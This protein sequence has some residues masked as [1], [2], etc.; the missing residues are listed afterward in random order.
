MAKTTG[1]PP[2]N[3]PPSS[4]PIPLKTPLWNTSRLICEAIA[5]RTLLAFE[6]DG[7][8]RIVAPYL[9]GV[10][11]RKVDI[12][13]AVQVGGWSRSGQFGVGKLWTVTKMVEV[14]STGESFQPD[15]PSY[16][17]DDTAMLRIHCRV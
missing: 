12:L 2:P 1:A 17:P 7:H 14:R 9:H 5:N 4:S 13:R 16:N 6:Y 11:H 10:G 8:T 3:D 15:D